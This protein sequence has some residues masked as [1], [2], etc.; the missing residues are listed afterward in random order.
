MAV[1]FLK[2]IETEKRGEKR[3]KMV[4][5][6]IVV[7]E[8]GNGRSDG[9]NNGKR[10]YKRGKPTKM[11]KLVGLSFDGDLV[12]IISLLFLFSG[13]FVLPLGGFALATIL[14]F[15]L[16]FLFTFLFFFFLFFPFWFPI[17]DELYAFHI[18]L[19]YENFNHRRNHTVKGV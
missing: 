12:E 16:L 2:K 8:G 5:K 1:T 7:E 13:F 18:S 14:V 19:N 10:K 4:E 6:K 9:R 17:P 3:K 11:A 15:S